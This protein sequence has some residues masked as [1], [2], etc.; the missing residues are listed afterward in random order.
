MTFLDV[1]EGVES[2]FA[3]ISNITILKGG[4]GVCLSLTT[5]D[6]SRKCCTARYP[7]YFDQTALPVPPPGS[8]VVN[9]RQTPPLLPKS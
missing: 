2:E 1:F 7:G 5:R 6:P 3:M 8:L 4:G 9:D